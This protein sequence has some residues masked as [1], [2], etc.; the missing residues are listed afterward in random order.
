MK[1]VFRLFPSRV[2]L[3]LLHERDRKA[4]GQPAVNLAFDDERIDH[5]ATV[6]DGK[7][8]AHLDFAGL[9][10][11]VHDRDVGAVRESHVRRIVVV[12]R[13]EPGLVGPWLV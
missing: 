7:E 13:L 8:A 10:I 11:D 12:R 2:V 3:N 9:A 4:F 5:G 1:F 6:V